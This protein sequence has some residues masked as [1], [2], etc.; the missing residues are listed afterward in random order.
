MEVRSSSLLQR[1]EAVRSQLTP[2]EVLIADSLRTQSIDIAFSSAMTVS[3]RLGV[4]EAT[5]IRFAR[6]IGFPSYP[7]L[8]ENIREEI[9]QRLN[10]T[11]LD[12][13]QSAQHNTNNDGPFVSSLKE[14]ILNLQTTLDSLD[15]EV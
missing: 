4:S 10:Q 7:A 14:D 6:T 1:I 5:L 2:S 3:S 15:T 8:Q 12:R 11:T 9:R 13:L